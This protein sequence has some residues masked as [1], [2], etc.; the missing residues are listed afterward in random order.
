MTRNHRLVAEAI[1][2]FE[3]DCTRQ[4]YASGFERLVVSP[5]NARDRLG[6]FIKGARKQL[7]RPRTSAPTWSTRR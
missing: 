4:P 6:A 2:L 3:A 5:E 1:K 7:S